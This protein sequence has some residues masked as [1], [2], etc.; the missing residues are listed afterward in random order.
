M[1]TKTM[2]Y[3]H[4]LYETKKLFYSKQK[5]YKKEYLGICYDYDDSVHVSLMINSLNFHFYHIQSNNQEEI[6]KEYLTHDQ[7][8]TPLLKLFK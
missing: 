2:S 3:H 5:K 1:M 7:L 8:L 4:V 6:N